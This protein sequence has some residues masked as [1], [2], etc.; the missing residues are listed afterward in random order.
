MG[1]HQHQ[2]GDQIM[3]G[4]IISEEEMFGPSAAIPRPQSSSAAGPESNIIS[5]EEMFGGLKPKAP[6][7]TEG[8]LGPGATAFAYGVGQGGSAR[9]GEE[10]DAYLHTALERPDLSN[11]IT[12]KTP[13]ETKLEENRAKLDASYAAHPW[14]YTAGEVLGGAGLAI[15]T[16]GLSLEAQAVRAG[17][18]WLQRVAP[19]VVD[20][21]GYGTAFGAG[22]EKDGLLNRLRSGVKTGLQAAPFGP[23][24]MAVAPAL[25]SLFKSAPDPAATAAQTGANEFR[26]PLDRGQAT[27]DIVAQ[28]YIDEAM[29]GV[30][31]DAAQKAALKF[32]EN[33]T[34]MVNEAKAGI[35]ERLDPGA[36]IIS[37]TDEAAT[38]TLS[39]VRQRVDDM[40]T[41][42]NDLY[43]A[44]E[45]TNTKIFTTELQNLKPQIDQALAPLEP[46]L[47]AVNAPMT[48]KLR[49]F[50]NDF[51]AAKTAKSGAPNVSQMGVEINGLE[52]L[53]QTLN[54]SKPQYGTPD[55]RAW[56]LMRNAF[57]DWESNAMNKALFSGDPTVLKQ[58][59]NARGMVAQLKGITN[60]KKGDDAGRLLAKIADPESNV[61]PVEVSNWLHG[62]N[63]L[64]AKGSS[65]RLVQKMNGLFGK[66]SP[67]MNAIRQSMWLKAVTAPN[68]RP[69]PG[70]QAVV[71]AL[72]KMLDGDGKFM[73][74]ALYDS[75]QIAEM[76]RFR[77][78]VAKLVPHNRATN[79]PHSGS[80]AA[81]AMKGLM[82]HMLP[83][84]GFSTHGPGGALMGWGIQHL[85]TPISS[86]AKAGKTNTMLYRPV[87]RVAAPGQ[88]SS[89]ALAPLASEQFNL[90]EQNQ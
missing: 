13:Y 85:A 19:A 50:I 87:P 9:F 46:V 61:T 60:P 82:W 32:R 3:P 38:N 18:P 53:R 27:G 52:K 75:R 83:I 79:P 28:R 51:V 4:D 8:P 43:K 88:R 37:G 76:G 65:V 7:P 54:M 81:I 74:Q 56:T 42:K 5:E 48:S 63:T 68:G 70:P 1:R 49:S 69:N 26:V 29:D 44:A 59:K 41:A 64:G 89:T 78:T 90:L 11:L 24:A 45:A 33:Q 10:L 17:L 73:T 84:F 71:S 14:L 47:D 80:R 72:N 25:R 86:I 23:A 62:A 31:G 2:E 34:H 55:H 30:H 20:A 16:G 35:Q 58:L 6:A 21:F 66:Q 57:D 36:P 22:G 15:G 40:T 67:E 77:D 39:S 12:E